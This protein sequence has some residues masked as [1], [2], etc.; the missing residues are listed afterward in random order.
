MPQNMCLVLIHV[1]CLMEEN[2]F[3][4]QYSIIYIDCHNKTTGSVLSIN[5]YIDCRGT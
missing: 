4:N 2:Q 1:F 5:W 3:L